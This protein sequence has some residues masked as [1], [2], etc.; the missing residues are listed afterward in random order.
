MDNSQEI[1]THEICSGSLWKDAHSDLIVGVIYLANESATDTARYPIYVFFH[2]GKL[3]HAMQKERFTD[4][5]L[6]IDGEVDISIPFDSSRCLHEKSGTIY[7]VD[8]KT[9]MLSDYG[10]ER[11]ISYRDQGNIWARPL[12]DWDRSMSPIG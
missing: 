11:M 6:S 1:S 7:T 9:S 2:D 3:I 8:F 4:R 10:L 12:S 5:F